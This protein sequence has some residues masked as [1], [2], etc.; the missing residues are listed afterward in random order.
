M[1][2]IDNKFG[3]FRLLG[4]I[5]VIGSSMSAALDYSDK[6]QKSEQNLKDAYDLH[7]YFKPFKKEFREY[8]TGNIWKQPGEETS[9]T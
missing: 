6:Q 3:L 1:N 5:P 2:Q 9:A 8:F 7:F 4:S